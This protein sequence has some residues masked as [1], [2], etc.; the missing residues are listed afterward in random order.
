MTFSGGEIRMNTSDMPTFSQGRPVGYRLVV[1]QPEGKRSS[2]EAKA[3]S[4]QPLLDLAS[5]FEELGYEFV[6]LERIYGN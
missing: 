5:Q 4:M 1:T 6:K 3:D 2:A